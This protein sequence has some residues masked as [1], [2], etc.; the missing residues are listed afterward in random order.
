MTPYVSID[1]ETTGLNPENCQVLE[2]GAVIEDWVSPIARLSK[3]HCL[4][5]YDIYQGQPFA[6]S[7]NKELFEL[8]HEQPDE[9]TILRPEQVYPCFRDWLTEHGITGTVTPAGK[10]FSGFDKQFLYKL[11]G[12]KLRFSHRAIDPAM[13]YWK[14]DIDDKLPGMELCLERAGLYPAVSHVALE[15][16]EQVIKLVRKYYGVSC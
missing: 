6:L 15:D 11:P 14:P 13:L 2:I 16:A 1:I 3:F 12:F 10:N 9:V 8:L 4:V 5:K 7:L